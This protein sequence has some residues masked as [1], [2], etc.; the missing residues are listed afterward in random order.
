MTC[1]ARSDSLSKSVEQSKVMLVARY[2]L[3]LSNAYTIAVDYALLL[4]EMVSA[5]EVASQPNCTSASNT[6]AAAC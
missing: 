5:C 1:C 6:S 4:A 2:Y 3:L